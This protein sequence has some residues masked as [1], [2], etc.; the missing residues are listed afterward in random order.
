LELGDC[1][2]EMEDNAEVEEEEEEEE[3]GEVCGEV[4][5]FPCMAKFTLICED[6]D[7]GE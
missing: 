1:D 6:M 5:R 4:E 2:D 3:V 7:D